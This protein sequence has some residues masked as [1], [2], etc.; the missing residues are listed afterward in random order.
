MHKTG[1]FVKKGIKQ[2]EE[3]MLTENEFNIIKTLIEEEMGFVA[4]SAET[5]SSNILS[6]YSMTLTQIV[7]KLRFCS[8]RSLSN[9]D[10]MTLSV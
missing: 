10:R 8:E 4:T 6:K 5:E 1:F 7:E 2:G 3:K 9:S